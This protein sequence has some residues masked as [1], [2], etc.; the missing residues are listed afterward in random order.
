MSSKCL[1]SFLW[2]LMGRISV[3]SKFSAEWVQR[4]TIKTMF[5]CISFFSNYIPFQNWNTAWSFKCIC[6]VGKARLWKWVAK[7]WKKPIVKCLTS[8]SCTLNLYINSMKSYGGSLRSFSVLEEW[9]VLKMKAS[10]YHFAY[11]MGQWSD[12]LFLNR[13]RVRKVLTAKLSIIMR[14]R[15]FES[16]PWCHKRSSIECQSLTQTIFW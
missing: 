8:P 9:M 11:K 10:S 13:L 2:I 5:H 1:S 6:G 4:S 14:K 16:G 7:W 15:N 12:W 3:G